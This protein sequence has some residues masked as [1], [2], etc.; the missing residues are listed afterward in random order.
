MK[1]FFREMAVL[2]RLALPSARHIVAPDIDAE[3]G[4]GEGA[5]ALL[6]DVPDTPRG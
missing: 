2:E 4:V 6:R 3:G 1:A 5:A